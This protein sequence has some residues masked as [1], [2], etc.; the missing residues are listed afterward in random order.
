MQ[1]NVLVGSLV[2]VTKW[3]ESVTETRNVLSV[4]LGIGCLAYSDNMQ[5]MLLLCA[6]RF[7]LGF[8]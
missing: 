7:G 2:I 8:F 4:L 5:S 1:M 6:F 3:K